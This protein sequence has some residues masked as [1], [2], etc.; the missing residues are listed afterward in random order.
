MAAPGTFSRHCCENS[1]FE[2]SFVGWC[3]LK[4]LTNSLGDLTWS[5]CGKS[6]SS[7]IITGSDLGQ[8][9]KHDSPVGR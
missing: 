6:F 9:S 2:D 4:A 3:S 5:P 8:A 1:M 7:L